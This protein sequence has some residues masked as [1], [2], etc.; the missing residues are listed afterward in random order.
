M[1]EEEEWRPVPEAAFADLYEVSNLGRMRSR[2]SGD[3]KIKTPGRNPDGYLTVTLYARGIRRMFT[4]HRLVC[5]AFKGEQP[6]VLHNEVA[7]LDGKRDNARSDNLKWVSKVE[8]HSH[9]RLHGTHGA[10]SKHPKAKLTEDSVRAAI[11]LLAE[12]HTATAVAVSLGVTRHA[13]EDIRS[14]KNWRHV[15]RPFG[16]S[17]PISTGNGQNGAAN[18]NARLTWEQVSEFRRRLAAGEKVPA[19]RLEFGLSK[20]AAYKLAA[21][22]TYRQAGSS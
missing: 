10:G 4:L 21:G 14:G 22:E 7:H 6:N 12:G 19:L 3:W 1:T 2:H 17:D 5:R 13:I 16:F 9:K 11:A 8:N 15:E 20:A 18:H